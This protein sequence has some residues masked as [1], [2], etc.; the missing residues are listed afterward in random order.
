MDYWANRKKGIKKGQII[1]K[2]VGIILNIEVDLSEK[3]KNN[4]TMNL[5]KL[6]LIPLV[7][8]LYYIDQT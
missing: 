8:D 6:N 5:Y 3:L 4:I 7:E 2:S 1:C